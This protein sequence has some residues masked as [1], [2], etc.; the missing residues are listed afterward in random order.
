MLPYTSS[1]REDWADAD[2]DFPDGDA[3]IIGNADSET[4]SGNWEFDA[5]DEAASTIKASRAQLNSETCDDIP[6]LRPR[7]PADPR[8]V[9]AEENF[10]G[11]FSLPPGLSQL[12]LPPLS[13][14]V[15]RASLDWSDKDQSTTS[16]TAS[17]SSDTFTTLGSSQY[18]SPS[19]SPHTTPGSCLDSSNEIDFDGLVLPSN[20]FDSSNANMQL[21][22]IL[23]SKKS[24][25][26]AVPRSG[27]TRNED[28]LELDYES[29]LIINDD[30]DFSPGRLPKYRSQYRVQPVPRAKASPV[31]QFNERSLSP[32]SSHLLAGRSS[33]LAFNP[34]RT[35]LVSKCG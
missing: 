33:S 7:K 21:T 34:S 8:I 12:S 5:Q 15:S 31:Q 23:K 10:E 35:S 16:S 22:R 13:H 30:L 26:A 6:T 27:D 9:M 4:S 19:P 1:S 29:G 2:F 17:V 18:L 24:V 11:D 32:S 25:P 14:R 28:K 3:I 20:I